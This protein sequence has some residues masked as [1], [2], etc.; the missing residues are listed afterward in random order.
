MAYY[1]LGAAMEAKGNFAAAKTSF[2]TVLRLVPD[3]PQATAMR[4]F[5]A[6]HSV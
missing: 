4:G 2:E 3:H 1:N 6:Q 5:I